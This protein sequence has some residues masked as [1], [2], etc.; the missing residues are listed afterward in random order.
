MSY[1]KNVIGINDESVS[2]NDSKV[3][4]VKNIGNKK[5]IVFEGLD[6][7]VTRRTVIDL[8]TGEITKTNLSDSVSLC[9]IKTF[10]VT[11]PMPKI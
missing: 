2:A 11:L 7:N 3:L 5:D 9:G 1:R 6:N 8:V 4:S 10:E